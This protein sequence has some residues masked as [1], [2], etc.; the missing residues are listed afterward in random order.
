MS[1]AHAMKSADVSV[2]VILCPTDFSP[3]AEPA[4][5]WASVLSRTFGAEMV[6]LHV[7]DLSLGALAGLPSEMAMVPAVEQLAG[8]VRAEATESMSRLAARFPQAR[9]TIR[10]G[11]PR[12]T[13]LDAA[14]E[15]HADMIVMGTHGRTGLSHVFFGSVAEHV[16]RHSPI[17]VL[18]VRQS[19]DDPAQ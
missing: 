1:T 16:V 19:D 12:A 6:I 2:K 15:V 18:T 11:R 5:A 10:E 17:P 14:A 8:R 3:G 13:I 7:L 4:L 9:T